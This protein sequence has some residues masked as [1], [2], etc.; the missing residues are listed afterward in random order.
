[1]NLTL[2]P[3]SISLRHQNPWVVMIQAIRALLQFTTILPLGKTAPF[4]DFAR[5]TWLYP[6]AG[7]IIGGIAGFILFFLPAPPLVGAVIAIGLVML[8]SGA[9]HLDGLFDFGD[10]L[11]AHGSPDKRIHALTDRQIGTGALALGMLI[12]ILSIASLGSITFAL[13]AAYALIFAEVCGKWSM[14]FLTI[15]GKPFHEGLHATLHRQAK[16]WFLIPATLLLIPAFLLPF[17]IVTKISAGIGLIL[18][19]VCMKFI[20]YRL[21]GG[22]NGDVTGA[23]GEICR[24]IMLTILGCSL[25][26]SGV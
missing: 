15:F 17:P 25:S 7:Y 22:V 14:A 4:E 3:K 10:G 2:N 6:L 11:M 19:P 20:A 16:T 23:S 12:T 18:V 26:I 9:N 24:S 1:M 5:N 13:T 8:I 21:F